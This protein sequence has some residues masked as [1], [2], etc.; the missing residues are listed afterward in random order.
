MATNIM[1]LFNTED[2]FAPQ[3]QAFQQR[4]MQATDPRSFIAAVGGNMGAQL[5]QAVPGLLGMPNKQ[6]KVRRIMQ[7]VGSISDPLG[8]AKEAYKLF[9]QEGMPQE[10][11]A[12][13]QSIQ[14]LQKESD[15]NVRE[16]AKLK[17]RETLATSLSTLDPTSPDDQLKLATLAAQ[18]GEG[19]MAGTAF[20]AAGSLKKTKAEKEAETQSAKNRTQ[21]C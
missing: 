2:S 11:Q 14:E 1:S 7:A 16:A 12:V 6:Q 18:A 3:Q 21:S 17:A 9:Q 20:T 13:L 8:Q 15:A 10:A 4:L 19:S 5:G